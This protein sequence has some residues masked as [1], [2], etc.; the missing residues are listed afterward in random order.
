MSKEECQDLVKRA[1]A[2]AA[3]RDSQSGMCMY[4][5]KTRSCGR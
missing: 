1:L 4:I 2:L 3:A 5:C